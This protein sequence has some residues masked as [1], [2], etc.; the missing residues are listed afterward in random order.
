M[1]HRLMLS[2]AA[3]L[4]FP[5]SGY[6]GEE[7]QV[8]HV[9]KADNGEKE[10]KQAE[11]VE[12]KKK[13][14]KQEQKLTWREKREQLREEVHVKL[15][16]KV[17]EKTVADALGLEYPADT[18]E[19]TPE[20]LEELVDDAVEV[21]VEKAFPLSIRDQYEKEAKEAI[22]LWTVG[23]EVTIQ[24]GGPRPRE[25]EGVLRAIGQDV[26]RIS[27]QTIPVVDLDKE[28]K[29]HLYEDDREELREK[30]VRVK[31]NKLFYQR[32]QYANEIEP[33]IRERLYRDNG[34]VQVRGNWYPTG[35]VIQKVTEARRAKLHDTVEAEVFTANGFVRHNDQWIPRSDAELLTVMEK[36]RETEDTKVAAAMLEAAIKKHVD[37][38]N[39]NAA[40]ALLRRLKRGAV[41]SPAE[42]PPLPPEVG[43]ED[44]KNLRER[45]FGK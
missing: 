20:E 34:Y 27:D 22:Q 6:A 26:I 32:S 40:K 24:V 31:M 41:R 15:A 14:A 17:P 21:Q 36:A 7:K 3:L 38:S 4:V 2:L 19:K 25:V 44:L 43:E 30:Y 10:R 11:E 42:M 18:P 5:W 1:N 16:E 23:E 8:E 45:L 39:V 29:A 12:G 13:E 33:N 28:T 9:K 37:A 35:V